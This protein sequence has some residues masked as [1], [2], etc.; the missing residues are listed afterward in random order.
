MRNMNK[1]FSVC[2]RKWI[3]PMIPLLPRFKKIDI[4]RLS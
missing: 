2:N 3:E 4:I 1:T